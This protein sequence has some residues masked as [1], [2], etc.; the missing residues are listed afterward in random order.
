MIVIT[1]N[2]DEMRIAKNKLLNWLYAAEVNISLEKLGYWL[3]H[4][5]GRYKLVDMQK[6]EENVKDIIS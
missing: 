6:Q 1:S 2:N 4:S 5:Q 3:E